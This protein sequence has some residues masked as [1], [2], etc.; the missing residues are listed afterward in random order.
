MAPDT[1]L[2]TGQPSGRCAA[3]GGGFGD[4]SRLIEPLSDRSRPLRTML[5]RELRFA[6]ADYRMLALHAGLSDRITLEAKQRVTRLSA[7]L[8]AELGRLRGEGCAPPG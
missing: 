2:D 1:F 5:S 8:E 7:L 4:A 3:V 6:E